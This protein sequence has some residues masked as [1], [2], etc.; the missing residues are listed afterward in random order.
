MINNVVFPHSV[1]VRPSFV[2]ARLKDESEGATTRIVAQFDLVKNFSLDA[3]GNPTIAN[4]HDPVF[5]DLT[6]FRM[7]EPTS[8]S[9][10]TKFDPNNIGSAVLKLQEDVADRDAKIGELDKMVKQLAAGYDPRVQNLNASNE[11]LRRELNE[12]TND[13]DLYRRRAD[14]NAEGLRRQSQTLAASGKEVAE[15]KSKVAKLT[16]D[17]LTTVCDRDNR[18]EELAK[19]MADTMLPNIR[20]ERDYYKER[21]EK[22]AKEQNLFKDSLSD[23]REENEEEKKAIVVVYEREIRSLEKKLRKAKGRERYWTR[24]LEI[25]RKNESPRHK[26]VESLKK[27]VEDLTNKLNTVNQ[28]Y[29][30]ERLLSKEFVRQIGVLEADIAHRDSQPLES[31]VEVPPLDGKTINVTVNICGNV[32]VNELNNYN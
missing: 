14:D 20:R 11:M 16:A 21:A 32:T 28:A 22:L 3:Y 1:E 10:I 6:T 4:M 26:Q 27:Q 2:V 15:L 31:L 13:R 17:L 19:T 7:I 23:V 30:Q 8:F 12:V 9:I 5:M 18:V 24:Q 29:A 25:E